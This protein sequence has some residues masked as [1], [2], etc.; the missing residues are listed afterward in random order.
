MISFLYVFCAHSSFP[1]GFNFVFVYIFE[2]STDVIPL[3]LYVCMYKIVTVWLFPFSH[4]PVF[5]RGC[6]R[7]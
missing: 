1:K 4:C 5:S 2:F 6:F 7:P 3:R